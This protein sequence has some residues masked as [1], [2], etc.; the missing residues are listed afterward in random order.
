[1]NEI[2]LTGCDES[3]FPISAMAAFGVLRLVT[4]ATAEKQVITAGAC[5]SRPQLSW[6]PQP[7]WTPV[8]HT[9]LTRAE[10]IHVLTGAAAQVDHISAWSLHDDLRKLTPA[11]YR[12]LLQGCEHGPDEDLA[13]ALAAEWPVTN[14]DR[15][16]LTPF[17][18]T[19]GQQRWCA[20]VR[21]VAKASRGSTA[22]GTHAMEEAL[23]GPWRY[24]HELPALGWDPA[25]ERH[26]ALEAEAPTKSKAKSVGAAV[27]L[28]AESLA[29][30]PCLGVGTRV[31]VPCFDQARQIFFWPVWRSGLTFDAVRAICRL[32]LAKSRQSTDPG[33]TAAVRQELG[34]R[35]LAAVFASHRMSSPAGHGYFV[36]S[37]AELI[38]S[39]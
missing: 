33:E 27:W 9:E 16:M 6:R 17:F 8:L 5:P 32:P 28:A 2:V 25:S 35:G 36:F 15:L 3:H 21:A 31:Q 7:R 14:D 26:H 30:F 18:M 1:M 13:T 11:T 38:W 20:S 12:A 19:S 37:P 10:L 22:V 4:R 39:G 29:L 23:F 24:T 34:M